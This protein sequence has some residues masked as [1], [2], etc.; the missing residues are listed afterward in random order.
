VGNS[1][2]GDRNVALLATAGVTRTLAADVT[3]RVQGNDTRNYAIFLIGSGT[4]VRLQQVTALAENGSD[5]N[6]GLLIWDGAAAMLRG[7]SFTGRAGTNTY[8]IFSLGSDTTLEAESVTVLAENSSNKNFGLYN[9]GG[10]SATLRG[11]DFTGRGGIQ[12]RGIE[13]ADSGSTLTAEG[14]T[15]LAENGSSDNYGFGSYDS[16]TTTLRG[17]DFIGRGGTDAYGISN[18]ANGATLEA[19]SVTALAENGSDANYGQYNF[20]GAATTLRGGS[21]TGRGGTYACGIYN[22][23]SG[24]TL[25]AESV[26]ALGEDGSSNNYGLGNYN[27]ADAT[28]RGGSFTARGETQALGIYNYGSGATLEAESVTALGENSSNNYGLHNAVSAEALLRGGSFTGRGGEYTNG[29]VNNAGSAT[30]EAKSVTAL[31]ENG[32]SANYGLRNIGSSASA[33]VTQSVLEGATWSVYRQGGSVTV[34]NSRLAGNAVSGTVTCVL[35]TRGTG[36]GSVS[37]DGSTCP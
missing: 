4:G 23:D 10:A 9:Y 19:E 8:G 21:F 32:S 31:G 11:G 27:D 35:V 36:G 25:A 7:G 1:G 17:G 16:V 3:A 22:I 24:T 13:N 26:T 2:A 29:I 34:S 5:T 33:N 30:L 12:T 15:A 20:S 28:L 37:T 18:G 14:V 6:L